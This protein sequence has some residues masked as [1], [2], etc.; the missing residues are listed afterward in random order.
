MTALDAAL[1]YVRVSRLDDDERERKVSPAMQRDKALALPQLAGL[2]VETFDRDLDMSGKDTA[3]RPDYLRMMARLARGGVRYVVAYDQSRITRNV[4]DLQLFRDALLRHGALFIEA[5]TGRVLDPADEDQELGSNVLGS[6]DQHYRRKVARRVRDSLANKAAGGDLVGPVP[7]GYVRRRTINDANGHVTRVWVEVDE[8]AADVVRTIFREYATGA[9]SFKSLARSLNTRGIVPPQKHNVGRGARPAGS[10][11]HAPVFTAD[12]LKDLL[13]NPRYAGRV[14]L[15]DGRTVTGTFPALV[16]TATFAACERVRSSQRLTVKSAPGAATRGS[17]FLLSGVLRCATCGSTMSGRSRPIDRTHREARNLYTCYRRRVGAGCDA[18]E[19]PQ[20]AVESDLVAVLQTM[21]LPPGFARAVDKAVAARL[22]TTYGAATT[23]S[24]G[25]LAEREKRLTDVYL[26]GRIAKADYDREWQAIQE[27]R[28]A[29]T[30]AAPLPL[31]TQQQSLL[32]TLVDEWGGM[33]A[34]ERKRMLTA[35]FET[36]TASA[37]GLDRL[38]PCEDWRPYV[39]AAIP[40]PVRLPTA[41][42]GPAE[43]KTGFEP[44]TPSLAR[45]CATTAPLPRTTGLYG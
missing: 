43:R 31:F 32:R 42:Q 2:A 18:P 19:V 37:D 38:E 35:I 26:A 45:T 14:P 36:V 9:H 39:V 34:D 4:S 29:L 41:P 20:E 28:A 24:V 12:S 11:A 5:A 7:A 25:A 1:L 40:K 27:Q 30:N 17:R 8:A 33:T 16:D 10:P 3:N 13:R 23:V 44:A 21:A 15:R 22:R 6:V